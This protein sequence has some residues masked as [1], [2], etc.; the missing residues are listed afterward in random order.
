LDKLF[1]DGDRVVAV[2]TRDLP[3]GTSSI[4]TEDERQLTLLAPA[5][6][7]DAQAGELIGV[8]PS[9]LT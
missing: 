5:R 1:P 8:A 6:T 4:T 2:A 3:A 9:D 7:A